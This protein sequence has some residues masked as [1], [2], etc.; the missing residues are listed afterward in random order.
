MP[1]VIINNTI[2]LASGN[3]LKIVIY[4]LIN[5]SKYTNLYDNT[6]NMNDNINEIIIDNNNLIKDKPIDL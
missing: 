1:T 3:V 4:G 6:A 2:I 5:F